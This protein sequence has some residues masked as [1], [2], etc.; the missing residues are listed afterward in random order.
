MKYLKSFNISES[1][2][3]FIGSEEINDIK[4]LLIYFN[5]IG[6]DPSVYIDQTG[7]ILII[8]IVIY[9]DPYLNIDGEVIEE[10]DKI[11]NYISSIGFKFDFTAQYVLS[12]ET[13]IRTSYYENF[14]KNNW[15]HNAFRNLLFTIKQRY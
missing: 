5:D 14:I 4:D 12:G 10:F 2:K 7:G 8:R 1:I 6:Y 15:K 11:Y 9:S 13:I 3:D